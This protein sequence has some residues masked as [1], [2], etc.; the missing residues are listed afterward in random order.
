M[1][2]AIFKKILKNI[3][4]SSNFHMEKSPGEAALTVWKKVQ[5]CG[6]MSWIEKRLDTDKALLSFSQRFFIVA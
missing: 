5:Y 4:I 6:A 2:K 1:I 3:E